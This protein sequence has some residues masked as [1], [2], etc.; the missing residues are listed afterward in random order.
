MPSG[1]TWTGPELNRIDVTIALK[2][3]WLPA[4]ISGLLLTA[5]FPKMGMSAL[6]W[7]ALVPL[8]IALRK[9]TPN[10]AFSVGM[11]AG[12]AHYLTLLYWVVFT[13]RTYGFLPW[14]QCVSLLVLLAAYLALY[15][16]LFALAL[17][18]LCQKPISLG[19]PR[20]DSL[21]GVGVYTQLSAD[22]VSLGI[23][24]IFPV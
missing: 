5:A 14:W 18:R 24:W 9:L 11:I 12:L 8:L 10:E 1:N 23:C 13:M 16:G 6:A 2:S 4:M 3:K 22:G 15:T 7:V 17:T 19:F 20:T 21:G